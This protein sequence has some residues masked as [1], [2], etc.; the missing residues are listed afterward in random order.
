MN[1]PSVKRISE[2][3]S[4]ENAIAKQIRGIMDGST[5]PLTVGTKASQYVK[6]CFNRPDQ[7]VVKL[8]AIDE[9]CETYGVE[10]FGSVY[11]T[12]DYCN[13]GDSYTPTVLYFS[14]SRRFRIGCQG[15]YVKSSKN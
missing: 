4:V 3:L 9:L 1:Y 8:Y 13:T 7:H 12:A 14:H 15:D 10:G 5:D 2:C 11:G 6:D